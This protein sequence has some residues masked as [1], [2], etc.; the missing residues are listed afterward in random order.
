MTTDAGE[1]HNVKRLDVPFPDEPAAVKILQPV[2]EDHSFLLNELFLTKIL[3][4][5]KYADKKVCV[6]GVA[7]KFRKGKSF[8]LNFFLRY[9]KFLSQG[10]NDDEDWLETESTLGGFSWRGGAERDT[11]GILWWS[12]PF[13]LKDQSGEEIVVLLMDTQGAFDSQST[14]K[15]CATVFALSTMI[16]SIQIYNIQNNIHEDDLQHLQLFTEYGRLALEENENKSK[17]FQS[18]VFLVRDWPSPYDME[19][20]FQGGIRLL[21]TRL[22]VNDRQ[23][24]ELQ[25]I[26]KHIKESFDEIKCFLM[27]HPG[28][29]VANSPPGWKGDITVINNDFKTYLRQFIPRILDPKTLIPKS[30]A[31]QPITCRELMVYLKA[32]IEIFAGEDMPEPKTVLSATAEANNLAATS[33]A[34]AL[35]VKKMEEVCGGDSPYISSAE[36]EDEHLRCRNEAIR[37]FKNAKKMGGSELALQFLEKLEQD[38]AESFESFVKQNQSKNLF[39]SMRTPAVLV[40]FMIVNYFCQEILQLIG[41]EGLA[42]IFSLMLTLVIVALGT[43]VYSRYSGNIRDIAGGIDQSVTWVWENLLSQHVGTAVGVAGQIHQLANNTSTT[44]SHKSR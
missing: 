24:T 16:S 43:W 23:H 42:S 3:A 21:D 8:L 7:G 28:L 10:G 20:G 30:I 34:K 5:P 31:G 32:Y 18:L 14:V 19:Y 41:L 37:F 33:S 22:Q 40:T 2:E 35:Y 4:N 38:I 6:V 15:D 29:E 13:L 36:L 1:V 39:K 11:D 25:Q 12:E 44:V 27:P 26:R 17:P 9:L